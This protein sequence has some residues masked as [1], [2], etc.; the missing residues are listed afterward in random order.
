MG[1]IAAKMPVTITIVIKRQ[2]LTTDGALV[3]FEAEPATGIEAP[4][5]GENV[6]LLEALRAFINYRIAAFH[7]GDMSIRP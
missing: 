1:V 6:C 2:A 4:P 3:A 7:R 5:L